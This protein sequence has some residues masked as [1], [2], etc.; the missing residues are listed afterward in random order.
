MAIITEERVQAPTRYL[1]S[2]D[3]YVRMHEGCVFEEDDR[4]ELVEG[5]II[6]MS[7]IGDRHMRCVNNLNKLLVMT[8]VDE[9]IV[10][11]Q[12]AVHLGMR[13]FPQPDVVVLT[14]ESGLQPRVPTE[15][16]VLLLVEVS[17]STL[18]FDSKIKLP[19]YARVGVPEVWIVNLNADTELRHN[20]P[21]EE[22]YGSL[23]TYGRGE[24]AEST[25]LPSVR[26]AV[27]DVL[28]RV[29]DPEEE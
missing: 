27:N 20:D 5:E 12:N 19:M 11:V 28:P 15:S 3:E 14:S 7:A 13:N 10:S 18:N 29:A 23:T 9:A 25:T 16:D 4:V 1:F 22:G 8:L 2:S 6:Q 24:V 21:A 17:D 26:L